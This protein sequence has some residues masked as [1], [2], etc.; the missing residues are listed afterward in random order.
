MLLVGYIEKHRAE[1]SL[2]NCE[3]RKP[4]KKKEREKS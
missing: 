1:C 2:N 4:I 3:L